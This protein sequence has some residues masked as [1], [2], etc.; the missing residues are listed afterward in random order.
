M[1]ELPNPLLVT[2]Q[3]REKELLREYALWGSGG[4]S[5]QK[6]SQWSRVVA[7]Y[8]GSLGCTGWLQQIPDSW[9]LYRIFCCH[10][11]V[12]ELDLEKSQETSGKNDRRR[13]P[14]TIAFLLFSGLSSFNSITSEWKEVFL[15]VGRVGYH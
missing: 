9:H 11:D 13:S 5:H 8:Q 10:L 14:R 4:H 7:G 12:D 3:K 15:E 2:H 6:Q 1:L